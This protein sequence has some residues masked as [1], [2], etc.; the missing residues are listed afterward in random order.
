MNDD[1]LLLIK[2]AKNGSS[3]AEDILYSY[4]KKNLEASLYKYS[5]LHLILDDLAYHIEYNYRIAIH[6]Y[7]VESKVTFI[8][9]ASWFIKNTLERKCAEIHESSNLATPQPV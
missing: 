4:H 3:K 5:F 2:A 9:F 1:E 8:N 7:N 6:K